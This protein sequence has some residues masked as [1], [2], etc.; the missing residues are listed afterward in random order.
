MS[1]IITTVNNKN[2]LISLLPKVDAF[3][4]GIENFSVNLPCD[5][6]L[7]ETKDIIKYIKKNNKEIFININKNIHSEEINDLINLLKEI[8]L[9]ETNGIFYYD[10]SI[11][12][13]HKKLNLKT[14]LVWAQEHL[15]TNYETINYWNKKNVK[16]TLLSSE[17]TLEETKQIINKAT[18]QLIMPIFGYQS[19]F[20]SKRPLLN[21]Y[22]KTFN[23]KSK[24][25][26]F[27]LE[28]ENKKYPILTNKL[29]TV[30]FTNNILNGILEYSQLKEK[31]MY[32]LCNSFNIQEEKYEMVIDMFKEVKSLNEK[33]F[34]QK[35]DQMFDNVDRGFL[36]KETVYKVK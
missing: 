19:M 27:Y 36:Y 29:G 32:I 11:V 7:S 34:V 5:F 13:L 28:K 14:D 1:K 15:T 22:F 31:P 3:L 24:S 23:I 30:S 25:K 4:I 16:Y 18:A 6:T 8:D 12:N 10:I 9:L 17:I 2:Q 20:V 35:I 26:L 21:N 33:E